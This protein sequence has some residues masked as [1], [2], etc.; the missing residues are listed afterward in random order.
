VIRIL[1]FVHSLHSMCSEF[2]GLY[3]PHCRYSSV[4]HYIST[5]GKVWGSRNQIVQGHSS[6]QH[7][8]ALR[9]LEASLASVSLTVPDVPKVLSRSSAGRC[10]SNAICQ[11]TRRSF[12]SE[13]VTLLQPQ[14]PFSKEQS[15]GRTVA[16]R[17]FTE[18]AEF[19][20]MWPSS[21]RSCCQKY[22][23]ST[24]SHPACDKLHK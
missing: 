7:S 12:W 16:W 8:E 15:S 6:P 18:T 1:I 21:Q 17:G 5:I 20:A 2:S 9:W 22:S 3:F 11:D 24:D 23:Y 14:I 13:R 4:I 10:M 19:R